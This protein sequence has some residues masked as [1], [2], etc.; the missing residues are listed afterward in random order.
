MSDERLRRL[1][2]HHADQG[3]EEDGDAHG[4]ISFPEVEI[5]PGQAWGG[6]P[7]GAVDACGRQ[8]PMVQYCRLATVWIGKPAVRLLLGVPGV[9]R[10]ASQ[11]RQVTL[12]SGRSS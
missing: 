8:L 4:W 11:G 3:D 6:T 9:V 7:V 12:A 10:R 5:G 2:A 1:A